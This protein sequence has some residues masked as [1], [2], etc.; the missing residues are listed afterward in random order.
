[1]SG[2]AA[3]RRGRLVTAIRLLAIPL[4]AVA[5][6]LLINL[7][8]F[9]ESLAPE[10]ENLRLPSPVLR[11]DGN[12][13]AFAMGFLAAPD[14]EPNESGAKLI[15]AMQAQRALRGSSSLD[16][17]ETN[18]ILGSPLANEGLEGTL[19]FICQARHRLDCTERQVARLTALD[20]ENPYL[21]LL[22]ERY[23]AL[24]A[25]PQFIEIPDPDLHT[26]WPPLG[27]IVAVGRLRLA[28]SFHEDPP[29]VFLARASRDL[30]F[31]RMA[32][33][34]GKRLGMKMSALQAIRNTHDFLS[35]L[36][37][38]RQ[39][40][41]AELVALRSLLRPFTLEEG[42]IGAAFLSEARAHLLSDQVPVDLGSWS[43]RLFLQR[44]AT[45][46]QN[47]RDFIEPMRLRA[48]LPAREY[49]Q[50]GGFEPLQHDFRWTPA[51][52][53]NLSGKLALSRSSWDPEQFPARV[54]DEDGR[55]VLLRLQ[56]R[57]EEHP[58]QDMRSLLRSP[59]YRNPYTGEPMEYDPGSRTIGFACL[60]TAFHP[61]E[62]AD[63]CTVYLG[64]TRP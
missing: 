24:L 44:N 2:N 64:D 55:V 6:V 5:A 41:P 42:D 3:N 8:V 54:H 58:D 39:L 35:A 28:V 15:K 10:L 22:F 11:V 25:Q 19:K 26:P 37:R 63:Q 32:L 50:R 43:T 49:Y 1:M 48:S 52:L 38:G 62:L 17:G 57:I 4:V 56:A 30:H 12:G 31:W 14:R 21:Q 45:H 51:A 29:A 18:E 61:P 53:Y 47:Y 36:M 9:D 23:D 60:H 59:E 16:A 34:G 46:N 13:Y 20:L 27:P 7:P 33:R 40:K